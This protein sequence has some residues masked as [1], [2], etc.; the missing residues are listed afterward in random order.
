[1]EE[2]DPGIPMYRDPSSHYLTLNCAARNKNPALLPSE[3]EDTR[4][5]DGWWRLQARPYVLMI[6]FS[7]K[8]MASGTVPSC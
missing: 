3:R 6:R 2:G 1:M 8:F 4:F 5:P 7:F